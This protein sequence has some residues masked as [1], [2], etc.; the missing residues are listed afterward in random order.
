MA[1]SAGGKSVDVSDK[2][3][4]EENMSARDGGRRVDWGHLALLGVIAF[5]CFAYLMNARSVSLS[6]QNLLFIEPAVL[7][8]LL[9]C[10]IILPQCFP[11]RADDAD[12]PPP[13]AAEPS[14]PDRREAMRS[15]G[16]AVSLGIFAFSFETV[17]FDVATWAFTLLT[18]WICGERKPLALIVFPVVVAVCIS[19]LV[20]LLVPFPVFTLVL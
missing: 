8:A 20:R 15:V 9:L 14:I 16:I 6:V 3:I 17:G 12:D 13:A 18:T 5:G 7:V 10:L 19:L 11:S 1:R 2:P 4:E